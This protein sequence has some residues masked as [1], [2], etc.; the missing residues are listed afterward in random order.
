VLSRSS[1]ENH[2]AFRRRCWRGF[3][4]AFRAAFAAFLVASVVLVFLA[5][6]AIMVIMLSQ[7]NL[8]S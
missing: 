8:N 5:L 6:V 4:V 3:L 1:Y 2:R 7:A